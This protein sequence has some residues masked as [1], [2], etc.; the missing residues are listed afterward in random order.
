MKNSRDIEQ[1]LAQSITGNKL[2][3]PSH[4]VLNHAVSTK[5]SNEHKGISSIAVTQRL[6]RNKFMT[7][8]YY[9]SS[10]VQVA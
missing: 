1:N 5:K 3:V 7:L 2:D 9:K 8:I 6:N 10:E 4:V